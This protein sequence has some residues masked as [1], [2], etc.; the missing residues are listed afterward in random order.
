[1]VY[2]NHPPP[3]THSTISFRV[4][5]EPTATHCL[6]THT[7]THTH[8]QAHT[9]TFAH[10]HTHT[11][12]RASAHTHTTHNAY[13]QLSQ[14]FSECNAFLPLSG[15]HPPPFLPPMLPCRD[16]R[17][18]GDPPVGAVVTRLFFYKQRPRLHFLGLVLTA[19]R[20]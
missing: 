16:P 20:P 3:H 10:T 11:H 12:A 1:M 14:C 9:N 4:C 5:D 2:S 13:T 7:L 8:K 19:L 15:N 18:T 17:T 6:T